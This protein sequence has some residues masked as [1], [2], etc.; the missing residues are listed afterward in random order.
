MASSKKKC[1]VLTVR[2]T[3]I[4]D[5]QVFICARARIREDVRAGHHSTLGPVVASGQRR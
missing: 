4:L 1:T 5:L 2:N 3:L